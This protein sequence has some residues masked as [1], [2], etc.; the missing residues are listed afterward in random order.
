MKTIILCSDMFAVGRRYFT[1]TAANLRLTYLLRRKGIEVVPIH[2]FLAFTIEELDEI[3][4]RHKHKGLV[5]GISTSFMHPTKTKSARNI[6]N[7]I[8][9]DALPK[10][11]QEKII[12]FLFLA[13]QY[14]AVTTMGGWLV[15]HGLYYL[16]KFERLVDVFVTGLGDGVLESLANGETQRRFVNVPEHIKDFSFHGSAPLPQDKIDFQESLTTELSTGC[17]FSCSF[18]GYA[19]L[20]KKKNEFVR[21]YESLKEEFVSNYQ[22]FGTTLY[23]FTDNIINDYPPKLEHVARIRD[24]TGIDIQWVAYARL[25]TMNPKQLQLIKDA[26]GIGLVF[27]LESFTKAA[28]PSIGKMTDGERLKDMLRMIKTNSNIHV[29]SSFIAGLPNETIEQM[30]S[31]FEWLKSEEGQT[32]V[33]SYL[34]TTLSIMEGISNKNDINKGRGDPFKDYIR[35]NPAS[36]KSPWTTS[37]ICNRLVAKF[38]KEH[39]NRIG[40]FYIPMLHNV[41]GDIKLT[42]QKVNEYRERIMTDK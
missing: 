8:M 10:E 1:K 11:D 42:Y 39:G 37:Q 9:Q 26:G 38:T 29:S 12:R 16:S 25:D 40:S 14:G 27:G 5:V 36:W 22:N 34:W 32:L 33:D 20:G 15:D 3:L 13:K 7:G 4:K 30:H 17:I 23:T 2:N 24:E 19:L 28:G 18:C 21:S 31:T 6:K 41:S 35:Y